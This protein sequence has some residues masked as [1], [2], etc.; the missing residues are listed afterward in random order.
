[1]EER[2]VKVCPD[3]ELVCEGIYWADI[4]ERLEQKLK[5]KMKG[6]ELR[7]DSLID[8]RGFVISSLGDAI[9]YQ[10]V[11][12]EDC[13]NPQEYIY[14]DI[15]ARFAEKL[16][17]LASRAGA[18][19][20]LCLIAHSLGTVI[21]SNFLYDLQNDKLRPRVRRIVERGNTPLGRGE[22]LTHF[23]M[24]GSPI[25]LWTMRF[26]DF[27]VPIVVPAPPIRSMQPDIGEWV[28]FYDKDDVIAYPIKSLN[29]RYEEHVTA[30]VEVSNPGLLSGT[31]LGSHGGYYKSNQ[32]LDRIVHSLAQMSSRISTGREI[33]AAL[34]PVRPDEG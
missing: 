25:A 7:W 9:A 26:E 16:G 8:A 23:Y 31:P 19:A 22:T 17:Q 6:Y 12:D 34:D 5:D 21:T 14:D 24:M 1:L 20:P 28:N 4:T 15:H 3:S 30:D 18:N 13:P 2:F 27:G 11:P 10:P 29:D 32:V 33:A